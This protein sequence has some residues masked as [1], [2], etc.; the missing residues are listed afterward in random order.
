MVNGALKNDSRYVTV[1]VMFPLLSSLWNRATTRPRS[2]ASVF[3][4]LIRHRSQLAPRKVKWIKRHK[5]T[6]PIPIGGSI[7]GTTLAY[8]EWGIRIKGNGARLTAKQLQTAEDV[9]KRKLKIIKGSKVFMRIFPHIPV[10][11]KVRT[12]FTKV[13]FV[14]LE[15]MTG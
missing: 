8:G 14:Y 5:G 2:I 3:P 10:C 1:T 13:Q 9:I 4:N 15:I 11:V 6:V 7:K 12:T